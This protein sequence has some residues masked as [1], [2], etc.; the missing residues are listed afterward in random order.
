MVFSNSDR[1]KANR[2]PAP[3]REA[4]GLSS[5]AL[6]KIES[7]FV[8]D[9]HVER[10]NEVNVKNKDSVCRTFRRKKTQKKCDADKTMQN[11]DMFIQSIQNF[12]LK[13]FH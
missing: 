10:L 4:R 1:S 3:S 2:K 6:D 7:S 9:P 13:P 11:L 12:Y 8:L 5:R